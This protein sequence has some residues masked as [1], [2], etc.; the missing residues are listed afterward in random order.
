[1]TQLSLN[2]ALQQFEITEANLE[3]VC[4]LLE[5]ASDS[6]NDARDAYAIWE[7]LPAIDGWKP[8]LHI[9]DFN[10]IQLMRIDAHEVG[11]PS[12]IVAVENDIASASELVD[13][14]AYRLTRKRLVL[15]RQRVLQLVAIV[16]EQVAS[17][18]S[19]INGGSENF[20]EE[21]KPLYNAVD[22]IDTLLGGAFPRPPRWNDL[23]RHLGFWDSCDV[24]D[25]VN[26]DWPSVRPV[27]AERLYADNEPIQI[28][29]DDLGA[30]VASEPEGP[31]T[32]Q[33]SWENLD[34][35]SF[36]RLIFNIIAGEAVYKDPQ[37]LMRTNAPDRGRDLS[38]FRVYEDALSGTLRQRVIIQCKHWMSK[39]VSVDEI[40][41]LKEQIKLWEPP[42]VDNVI[43]ATS[44]RFTS[45][46]VALIEKQNQS[47][48]S[49][50]IDMWPES[51][52]EMLLARR[53]ALIAECRLRAHS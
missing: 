30:L 22:E 38:V 7:A 45:D 39:S 3:K 6:Q 29:V 2:K 10:E 48:Q 8:S 18:K 4:R 27:L 24:H 1:M 33:L 17:L 34:A 36:E 20:D 47:G 49:P 32:T 9:Y 50:R 16:D 35:E 13:E 51:H 37:W 31:V 46:A 15:I 5:T 23:R 43:I 25:I 44:G 53:P 12:A 28:E 14:F 11:E 21:Y 19:K 42:T 52:I 40:A 41:A 26:H